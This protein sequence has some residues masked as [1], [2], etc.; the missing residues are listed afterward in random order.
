MSKTAKIWLVIFA[1]LILV[2]II[3]LGGV[4]AMVK[5]DFSKLFT[6]KYETNNYE[7]SDFQSISIATN[8][9]D[10]T[11]SPTESEKASVTCFEQS[12]LRHSVNVKNGTLMVEVTDN[13]KWYEYIGICF[14]SPKITICL[15]AEEYENLLIKNSTG[16][17]E[18][19][20]AFK[21]KNFDI[22]TTTGDIVNR[23]SA[24]NEMKLK[25]STGNIKVENVSASS[26]DFSVTTGKIVVTGAE[27]SENIAIGVSTGEASLQ[28][29]ACKNLTSKGNT[30]E[31]LLINTVA[32]EKLSIERTTGDVKLDRCDAAELWIKTDTG[33]VKLDRCDAVELWIKTDTGDITGT[34]LSDKIFF[35]ETDTGRVDVPKSLIGGKCEV[36]TDTGDIKFRVITEE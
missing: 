18:I 4:L 14:K 8:T 27:C 24:L 6:V 30:G 15:P 25:T 11:L 20:E 7:V 2:G 26:M 32:S 16:N 13:R 33:D 12:S 17:V 31:M 23:A 5:W 19:S 3:I 35:A 9:A 36:V 10:I 22:S 34:L 1:A 28:D 21:F 29:V